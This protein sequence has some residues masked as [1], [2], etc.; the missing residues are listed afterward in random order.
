[1]MNYLVRTQFAP[2]K[3]KKTRFITAKLWEAEEDYGLLDMFIEQLE[4]E[5]ALN[6]AELNPEEHQAQQEAHD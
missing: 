1:M 2:C 5:I 4:A 3:I 6:S